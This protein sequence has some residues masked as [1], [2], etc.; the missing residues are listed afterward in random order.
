VTTT[1]PHPDPLEPARAPIRAPERRRRAGWLRIR[2]EA[3]APTV[4]AAPSRGL[5]RI[6]W[7]LL[8][9]A[10]FYSTWAAMVITTGAWPVIVSHWGI[11][12]AMA[13]GS[14]VAGSTPMGGGTVGFPILVLVFDQPASLGRDFGFA[15]Q[16]I[17]M[18]SA[19]IFILCTGRPLERR[20]LG[21]SMLGA[22]VATPLS[23]AFL[24][25]HVDERVMKMLFAVVWG[26]FGLMHL[27]KIGEICAATG[28]TCMSPA[29]ERAAGLGI[30]VVGGGLIASLTG[31]GIDMLLYVVLVLLARADLKIAIPT[32]VVIMAFASLVGI[33]SLH[34]IGRV[35][36]EIWAP[37]PEL[38]GSWLAAAP[39]VA[40]GAPL[41][42]FV[43]NLIGR[44]PTLLFVSVLCLLQFV[45]MA[46]SE[47][48][49]LGLVGL[50]L[51][52][53]GLLL[54]N[55]AFHVMYGLG[56]RLERSRGYTEQLG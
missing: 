41:G 42:V 12:L 7:F 21:W 27:V 38:W 1:T 44:K 55:L 40:L 16:S 35:A 43:V 22:L 45:W 56:A 26:S 46:Y 33:G 49:N 20:L 51:S 2:V 39:I 18:T 13:A 31:V 4:A 9:L 14:Y 15:I 53:A 10:C 29:F 47:R 17:G 54:F 32:S 5:G 34:A 24:A 19:S 8:W 28:M 23:L 50:A 52:L 25:P 37:P 6:R 36:P 3:A 48:A 11:A 30:G